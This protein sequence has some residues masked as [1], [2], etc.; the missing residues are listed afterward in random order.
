MKNNLLIQLTNKIKSLEDKL[1]KTKN[2]KTKLENFKLKKKYN[3]SCVYTI[4][5]YPDFFSKSG[6]DGSNIIL[7]DDLNFR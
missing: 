1:N 4:Y 7:I 5:Y 2:F 3:F 6:D